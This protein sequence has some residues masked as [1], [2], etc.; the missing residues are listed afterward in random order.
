MTGKLNTRSD[1]ATLFLDL[2]RPT[3]QFFSPGHAYLNLGH[4]GVHYGERIAGMEGFARA[5]WGFAF[6]WHADN[7]GLTGEQQE[8]CKEWLD[9]FRDGIVNGTDP[10]HEEY[11]GGFFDRDQ[12]MVEARPVSSRMRRL[13]SRAPAAASEPPAPTR[14]APAAT[15]APAG[16]T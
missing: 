4:T 7:S 14:T 11:W 13:R 8:E 16:V 9:I 12:K 2:M 10:D 6:L 5:L 3:K 1:V 15:R